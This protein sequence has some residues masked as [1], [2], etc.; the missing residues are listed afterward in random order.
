MNLLFLD[1]Y[2]KFKLFV[3]GLEYPLCYQYK[4]KNAT[5]LYII[6]LLSQYYTS[7]DT[8]LSVIKHF[9]R[10]QTMKFS[11]HEI[12]WFYST[13]TKSHQTMILEEKK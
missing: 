6:L 12:K 10:H 2:K 5:F 3:T 4:R 9:H 1:L 13:G 7:L 11:A 8:N